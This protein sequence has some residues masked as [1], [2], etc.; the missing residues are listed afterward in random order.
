MKITRLRTAELFARSLDRDYTE[1]VKSVL[2]WRKVDVSIKEKGKVILDLPA[3]EIP[4]HWSQQAADMLAHKYLRKIGVFPYNAYPREPSD[5][6]ATTP[7]WLLPP[8]AQIKGT[9]GPEKSAHQ[10][11]RRIAGHWTYAGWCA[12]YF[13]TEQDAAAY[14]DEMYAMLYYQVAAPNSPQWFNTGIWWAYGLEGRENGSFFPHAS[15][16]SPTRNSYEYPQTSACF[17]LGLQDSLLDDGGILNTLK[18]EARIFKFGSGSGINYSTLRAQGTPL[19]NGG[20][21]SGLMS[22]LNTF[23]A[24]AGSIK[25]GGTTRRAARMAVVD[26]DHPEAEAFVTWKAKEEIKVAAM[27]AAKAS[28]KSSDEFV[29]NVLS[30][31]GS[32]YEGEAYRTVGGQNANNSLRVTNEFMYWVDSDDAS[33]KS[34]APGKSF[35]LSEA[36]D[37]QLRAQRLWS[38]TIDAAWRCGDPGLQFHDTCNDWHTIPKVA[39]Q[40][41]TNP[42]SEYSFIDDSAC[43]LASLN[44]TAF[45]G[46]NG[47]MDAAAFEHAVRLWIITLD[48]TIGMSSYPNERIA[49]NAWKWRTLG[50]GYANLGGLLM[51]LGV[52]YDSEEGRRIAATITSAMHAV[53]WSTSAEMASELGAFHEFSTHALDVALVRSKHHTAWAAIPASPNEKDSVFDLHE[54]ATHTWETIAAENAPVRNAQLTLLAPTG[55]ISFV[56]DAATTGVEPDFSLVKHKKLAGGGSMVIVNPLVEES[57]TRLGYSSKE[58]VEIAAYI[59][60]Q[61]RVDKLA[62][63]IKVEHIRIY[64]CANDIDWKGHVR[65]MIAVQPFLS[66]A[67]SKTV[68]MPNSA[69]REDVASAYL[70]AWKGGLKALAIYRDGCKLSQPLTAVVA[71]S[72]AT[73]DDGQIDSPLAATSGSSQ[74][75]AR[76]GD[77]RSRGRYKLPSRRRG[78]TQKVSIGGHK[79]YIR[80]GEYE[81]GSLGEIFLTISKEGSTLKHMLDAL[82]MSVS[83]GLQY[84]VPLDE[85]VDAFVGSKSDPSGLVQG[86]SSVKMCSSLMD[87]VF[88]ELDAEYGHKQFVHVAKV[89]ETAVTSVAASV[90]AAAPVVVLTAEPEAVEAAAEPE[91]IEDEEPLEFPRVVRNGA[92]T[93]GSANTDGSI[94]VF[95]TMSATSAGTT[96]LVAA[97]RYH[98][99]ACSNCGEFTLRSSG[100]CKVCDSCGQTTGCS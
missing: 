10:V 21:S 34:P 86:S 100:S 56:L 58:V 22:F 47:R 49:E 20:V 98:G 15:G 89:E 72:V 31:L 94:T 92:G 71:S 16:V 42:C 13:D 74:P 14:Y 99:D 26:C 95:R 27:A 70:M 18:E 19:S 5:A 91:L 69:T 24:N 41:A 64:D 1:T 65:M 35:T 81:D 61:G 28:M 38:K 12:N 88:K 83:L 54:L 57:L 55:T 33:V 52:P 17:I 44:L 80:T 85:Y 79:L 37:A 59:K 75:P 78:F 46:L 76:R 25:S 6:D 40:R 53:A 62:P 2:K 84:G 73:T 90:P 68:N 9:G 32:D 87:Y 67:I 39:P 29:A 36:I 43:N 8:S 63:H 48:I 30:T 96:K 82:A 51:L 45:L 11:F 50:L 93:N 23:D 60:T 77:V 7:S 97:P 4:E 3:L 66:G